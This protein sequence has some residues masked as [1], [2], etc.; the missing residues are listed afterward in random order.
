MRQNM[1]G[2]VLPLS[3]GQSILT[4]TVDLAPVIQVLKEMI[5]RLKITK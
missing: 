5:K 1:D 3:F 4:N 2:N